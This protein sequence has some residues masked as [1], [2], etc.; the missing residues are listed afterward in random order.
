MTLNSTKANQLT[1]LESRS[2][3]KASWA[4]AVCFGH[5]LDLM[6]AQPCYSPAN[7]NAGLQDEKYT[8]LATAIATEFR[9]LSVR[10]S[11]RAVDDYVIDQSH[12]MAYATN[13]LWAIAQR[14]FVASSTTWRTCSIPRE[15]GRWQA[16]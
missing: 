4:D 3:T 6:S 1:N 14:A 12:V 10:S 11:L 13:L 16:C 15:P 2:G 5:L 8:Q 9:T 7:N